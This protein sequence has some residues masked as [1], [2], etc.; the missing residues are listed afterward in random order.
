MKL[1]VNVKEVTVLLTHGTDLIRIVLD[2]KSSFPIMQYDTIIKIEC[3]QGYG[4]EYCK[5]VL[6]LTPKIID[7]R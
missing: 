4:V 3:Q 1:E 5:Y 2:E 6:G 7:V